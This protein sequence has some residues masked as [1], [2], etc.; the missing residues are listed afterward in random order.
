MRLIFHGLLA[1][2]FGPQVDMQADTVASAIEGYSRQVEWPKDLLVQVVGF[3]TPESFKVYVDEVHIMP[4]MRGG[5]GK[6]G[7]IIMGAAIVAAAFIPGIGP[8]LSTSM[9]L[10]GGL[11]IA[12]G[13]IGLFM[14]SPTVKGVDDPEASKYLAVNKNTTAIGT[15]ITLAWGRIDL[16]GHW[17]S[18]QSDSTNLSY[19]IFPANP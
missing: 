13:V 19:G 17:L 16:A 3:N 10:S 4:A 14:K 18:L 8:A 9:L 15:P 6:F 11:M 12:Q 2:K 1:D 5:G 7:S